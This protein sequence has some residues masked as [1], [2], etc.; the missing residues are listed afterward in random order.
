MRRRRWPA[1]TM[2]LV[3]VRNTSG[4][5]PGLVSGVELTGLPS[6]NGGACPGRAS[7]WRPSRRPGAPGVPA[8]PQWGGG[9]SP[10]RRPRRCRR[11]MP[12]GFPPHGWHSCC[13]ALPRHASLGDDHVRH[14]PR[15]DDARPGEHRPR[16]PGRARAGPHGAERRPAPPRGGRRPPDRHRVQPGRSP[17]PRR[18]GA[19]RYPWRRPSP[20]S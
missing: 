10:W 1:L 14:R 18:R 13:T 15:L 19:P 7:S 6:S 12:R 17:A 16:L 8:R 2:D 9:A 5:F 20:A 4:S 3:D 11:T